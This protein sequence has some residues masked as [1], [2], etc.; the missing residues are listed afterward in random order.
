MGFK[1]F[2]M[3]LDGASPI[4][5]KWAK[6]GNL[7]NIAKIMNDGVSGNLLSTIPFHTGVAW[8]AFV[9]GKNPGKTGF[10]GWR[11]RIPG[12][13]ES[14]RLNSK[15]LHN[16]FPLW[17]L[18]SMADKKVILLGIPITFPPYEI[19]GVMISGFPAPDISA[20]PPE[21]IGKLKEIGFATVVER[22][23]RIEQFYE[24]SAKQAEAVFY[25]MEKYDWDLFMVNFQAHQHWIQ[26]GMVL[27]QCQDLDQ[28]IGKIL[29]KLNKDAILII[30]SDHGTMPVYKD[31]FINDFL[32][33][34]G[35]LKLK[36]RSKISFKCLLSRLRLTQTNVSNLL[37]NPH[38][39]SFSQT[40]VPRE[41]RQKIYYSLPTFPLPSDID[42]S[43][44][45]AYS[46]EPDGIFI[47][48]KGRDPNGVIEPGMEFDNLRNYITKELCELKDYENG[49]RVIDEVFKKEEIYKGSY[50]QLAPDILVASKKGYRLALWSQNGCICSNSTE[51]FSRKKRYIPDSW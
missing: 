12:M 10:F 20:Y 30:M 16:A 49:G 26:H 43:Q 4:V 46:F 35:L 9:T 8:P 41:L 14:V 44:T 34:L 18:S 47:N 3:G 17:R 48:L 45:K 21:L 23:E 27:S 40:M 5:F 50:T 33:D 11:K 24:L 36:E 22:E 29:R 6:Q 25:I 37:V 31:V 15:D 39:R 38:L 13:Y 1:C 28:I 19:N 32:R 42:W 2:V 7:P 51:N